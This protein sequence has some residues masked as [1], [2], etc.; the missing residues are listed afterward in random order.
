MQFTGHTKLE[1]FLLYCKATDRLKFDDFSKKVVLKE[2]NKKSTD[3]LSLS[4][5]KDQYN[6]SLKTLQTNIQFDIDNK[7]NDY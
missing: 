7:M 4:M 2:R 6:S 1:D 3:K 5:I